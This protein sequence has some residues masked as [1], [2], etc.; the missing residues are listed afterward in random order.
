VYVSD[1]DRDVVEVFDAAGRFAY[2]FGG[3]GSGPGELL[4]PAG[5]AVA[6]GR[7][8]VADSQNGRVQAFDLA[9]GGS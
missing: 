9:G 2:A 1:A 6:G 4:L 5:V 8:F 3:S 7:A